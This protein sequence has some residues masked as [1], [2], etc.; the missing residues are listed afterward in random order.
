[1]AAQGEPSP[2]D[3][4]E[5]VGSH[6]RD[7]RRRR[8]IDG[9][10]PGRRLGR[11]WLARL[12]QLPQELRRRRSRDQGDRRPAAGEAHVEDPPLLLDVLGQPVGHEPGGGVVDHDVGPLPALHRVDRRQRD[13]V[14]V[15]RRAELVGQPR[16]GTGRRRARGGPA[17]RGRR[18][19]RRGRRWRRGSTRRG[20]WRWRR[21]RRRP[22]S[23]APPPARRRWSPRRRPGARRP[24]RPP[25][26]AS[27][28][29]PGRCPCR[30]ASRPGWRWPSTDRCLADQV[31]QR[32]AHAPLRPA[33]RLP[34]HLARQRPLGRGGHR[35]PRQR[36]P[37]AAAVEEPALGHVHRHAGVAQQHLH[38]RQRGVDPGQHGHVARRR[39]P[40][41]AAPA[42]A[43]AVRVAGRSAPS[44]IDNGGRGRRRRPGAERIILGDPHARC[45]SAGWTRR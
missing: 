26:R 32:R 41:D 29:P 8:P 16:P 33:G 5:G 25:G 35:Q 6:G 36:G 22:R 12:R 37:H 15:G 19:R 18:G 38:R 21:G 2:D 17:R 42:P 30:P 4:R 23:T 13:P 20:R 40:R 7:R 24:R 44:R 9:R 1:M 3:R 31:E 28:P 11:R 39:A 43:A 27:C 34:Q 14:G 45:G 10:R